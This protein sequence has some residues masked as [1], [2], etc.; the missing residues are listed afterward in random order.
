MR[1]Q[2]TARPE[3]MPMKMAIT[4]K[5]GSSRMKRWRAPLTLVW[6]VAL[7]VGLVLTVPP[8]CE[9][10]A[11]GRDPVPWGCH[12]AGRSE[13]QSARP[14]PWRR[15]PAAGLVPTDR[16]AHGAG[17]R[18]IADAAVAAGLDWRCR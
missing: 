7:G 18:R 3:R 13:P 16:R 1:K 4:R 9:K 11:A 2:T 15:P 17:E 12:T 8:L 6:G 5:N 10:E 14:R